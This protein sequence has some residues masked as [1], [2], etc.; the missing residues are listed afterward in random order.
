MEA[1]SSNNRLDSH[2]GNMADKSSS[3]AGDILKG[4]REKEEKPSSMQI[5]QMAVIDFVER[6]RETLSAGGL[7]LMT[8][9]G[10]RVRG[11][12]NKLTTSPEQAHRRAKRHLRQVEINKQAVK[13]AIELLKI[14]DLDSGHKSQVGPSGKS[15]RSLPAH[16]KFSDDEIGSQQ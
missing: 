11:R 16:T 4:L 13:D 8:G 3:L 15:S 9:I 7:Q 6:L 12:R 14:W 5:E 10:A 2:T 1:R